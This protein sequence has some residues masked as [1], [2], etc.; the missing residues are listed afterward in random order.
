MVLLQMDMFHEVFAVF[1]IK[2]FPEVEG[3]IINDKSLCKGSSS[4][5]DFNRW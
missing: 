5:R 4:G 1:G 3:V 2:I